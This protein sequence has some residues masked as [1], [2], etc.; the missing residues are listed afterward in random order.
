MQRFVRIGTALIAVAVLA[1]GLGACSS[2]LGLNNVTLVPKPETLLR[3]PDW[4]TF[5]LTAAAAA[6]AP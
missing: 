4:A 3:K 5:D 2:D 6:E 1:G